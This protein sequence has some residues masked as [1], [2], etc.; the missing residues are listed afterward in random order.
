VHQIS[1]LVELAK[2]EIFEDGLESE[3][4]KGLYILLKTQGDRALAA[5]ISVVED[6]NVNEEIAAEILL[7]LGRQDHESSHQARLNLL[8][9]CLQSDS[10]RVRDA[11][12]VALASMDDPN[13]LPALK[14]AI[15]RE[16][17]SDLRD[18]M[19]QVLAQL[20]SAH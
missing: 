16:K 1:V 4:T 9:R 13:A 11:A 10:A 2:D 18:D 8:E 19:R 3:F 15:G 6:E 7:W 5:L 20:E 14:L 12:S 17:Y